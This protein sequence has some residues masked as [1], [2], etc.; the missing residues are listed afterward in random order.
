MQIV[1]TYTFRPS[2]ATFMKLVY[3]FVYLFNLN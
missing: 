1:A 2:I 3:L